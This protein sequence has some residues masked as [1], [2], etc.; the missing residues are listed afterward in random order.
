MRNP[1]GE[2]HVGFTV[3]RAVG[4]AVQRNRA[5]RRLKA[6]MDE[7][8]PRLRAGWD[9]VIVARQPILDAEYNVI[10]S[11]ITRLLEQAGL[12]VER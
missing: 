10:R 11:G 5:R 1:A 12:M 4:G 2:L 3:S 7:L 8:I 9:M 6:C